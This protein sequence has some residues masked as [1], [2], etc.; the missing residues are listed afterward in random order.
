VAPAA[1]APLSNANISKVI[2]NEAA[3]AKFNLPGNPIGST[4]EAERQGK[5]QVAGVVKN[6]NFKSMQYAV[7]PFGL[8]V[9]PDNFVW[10]DPGCSL[11][12]KVKPH[13]NLPSLIS[14][15]Q[16]VYKKYDVETP[17][18]YS[19]MDDVFDAQYKAEDRLAAVFSLFTVIT[20]SLAA[21]G[22]FGL[23]AFTIQQRTK[24]IGIRKILGA[25]LSAIAALLSADF[26]KLVIL[27]IIIA[28]PVAWW[29]MHNW[30]QGFAY[31]IPMKLWMFGASGAIAV[32]VA[33]VTIG[34]HAV[35]AGLANPVKS[36]R[37]E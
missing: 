3:V 32:L 26:L 10:Q 5:L 16:A 9:V 33:V 28:S 2:L 13:T 18:S 12:A 34:Y 35:R 19:F 6:F 17:F 36:L 15:M 30:L 23:A 27:A 29:G 20:V 1:G 11:Y 31:R 22:L 37:S 14:A 7:E 8:F 25:S 4:L 24:E 21:L